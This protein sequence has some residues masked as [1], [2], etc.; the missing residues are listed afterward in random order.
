M[1][2]AGL[3]YDEELVSSSKGKKW[4]ASGAVGGNISCAESGETTSLGETNP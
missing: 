3:A 2:T 1:V 4:N